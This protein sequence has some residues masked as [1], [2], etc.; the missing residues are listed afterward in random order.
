MWS[1]Y[2]T[3]DL[4]Q[5]GDQSV[6]GLI[7][8]LPQVRRLETELVEVSDSLKAEQSSSKESAAPPRSQVDTVKKV[9]ESQLKDYCKN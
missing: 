1:S 9:V 4:E 7:L 2:F 8:P 3:S 6:D 5:T